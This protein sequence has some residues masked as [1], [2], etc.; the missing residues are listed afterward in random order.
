MTKFNSDR[1]YRNQLARNEYRLD[2]IARLETLATQNKIM[3]EAADNEIIKHALEELR[4]TIR[5]DNQSITDQM[6]QN[7]Q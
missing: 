3:P 5:R 7:Q 4:L 6:A 2:Q 1:H